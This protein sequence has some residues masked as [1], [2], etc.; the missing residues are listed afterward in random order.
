MKG[1]YTRLVEEYKELGHMSVIK[2]PGDDGF[3]MPHHAVI[4]ETSNTTKVRIV[5]DA[6]AKSSNGISLNDVLMVGSTI[7]DK[8]FSHLIRFRTYNYV[9]SADIEKMYRQVLL[10]ED[11]RRYQRILWREN[12]RIETFQLNTL[13]FGVSSSPFLAIRTIQR[14][15]NDEQ[16]TYPRAAQILKNHLYIDDLLTGARTVEEA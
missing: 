15:A 9:I 16:Q 11:D 10:H 12:G 1:E 13:T 8:L 7:Q 2:N 14:L 5:F 4:K 3:H 6:F